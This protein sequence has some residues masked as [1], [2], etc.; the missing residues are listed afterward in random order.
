MWTKALIEGS[1][2]AMRSRCESMHSRTEIWR[3]RVELGISETE[4]NAVGDMIGRVWGQGGR[5]GKGC[6]EMDR[7]CPDASTARPRRRRFSKG[8]AGKSRAARLKSA[9]KLRSG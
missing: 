2:R 6:R 7:S 9:G 3:A 5:G 1:R 8:R 4:A